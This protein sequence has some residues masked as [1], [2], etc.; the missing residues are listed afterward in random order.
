[1]SKLGNWI[2]GLFVLGV[3]LFVVVQFVVIPKQNAEAEQYL[4][5]Q[6]KPLTHDLEYI[7]QYKNP[8]MG[9]ASNITNLFRHLPLNDT[10]KDFEIKSEELTVMVNFTKKTTDI[11]QQLLNQSLI[12]NST[13]AFALIDNLEKIEYRF[14][15]QTIEVER[16]SVESQYQNF[17]ELTES[18]KTWNEK[19]RNPLKSPQYVEDFIKEIMN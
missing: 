8:Y 11:N 14:L 13:A 19:V 4:I 9:N 12:Y 17:N 5:D 1:M 18:T 3:I 15:D 2:I 10:L 7:K 16:Q 6:N